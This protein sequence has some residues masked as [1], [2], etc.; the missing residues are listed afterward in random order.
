MP[1]TREEECQHQS[2]RPKEPEEAHLDPI[3]ES[4]AALSECVLQD[5]EV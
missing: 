4:K 1:E 2:W 3:K 5:P